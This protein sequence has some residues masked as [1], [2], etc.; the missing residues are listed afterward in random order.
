MQTPILAPF[1][2]VTPSSKLP[3]FSI[4][5]LSEPH[6]NAIALRLIHEISLSGYSYICRYTLHTSTLK[7][8]SHKS[9]MLQKIPSK[10]LISAYFPFS[11]RIP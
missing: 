6:R 11:A 10:F 7:S 1:V 4:Q 2:N 8:R 5:T 9:D 3:G